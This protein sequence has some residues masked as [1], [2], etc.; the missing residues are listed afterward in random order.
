MTTWLVS[1]PFN[2]TKTAKLKSLAWANHH[3]ILHRRWTIVTKWL[4]ML[5]KA[6]GFLVHKSIFSSGMAVSSWQRFSVRHT[7][8]SRSE[9]LFACWSRAPFNLCNADWHK[10]GIL[11]VFTIHHKTILKLII[12]LW[13]HWCCLLVFLVIITH[14]DCHVW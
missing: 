2:S 11:S 10:W 9:H 7:D 3:V 6:S 13:L 1:Y 12:M 5:C 8:L 14:T 4:R